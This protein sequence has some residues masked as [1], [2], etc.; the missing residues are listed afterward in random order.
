MSH[1]ERQIG[2]P[3]LNLSRWLGSNS[4][5]LVLKGCTYIV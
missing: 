1:V 3:E 2:H 4:I 5:Q